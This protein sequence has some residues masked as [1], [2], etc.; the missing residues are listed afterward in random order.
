MRERLKV[1]DLVQLEK[2]ER[3]LFG[4]PP[5][6]GN[7]SVDGLPSYSEVYKRL[8]EDKDRLDN[9]FLIAALGERR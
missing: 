2:D 5:H 3:I 9:L 4:K 1:L 7:L 8:N 6:A